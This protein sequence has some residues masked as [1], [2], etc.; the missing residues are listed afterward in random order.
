MIVEYSRQSLKDLALIPSK[1]RFLIQQFIFEELPATENINE[2]NKVESLKGFKNFFK[3][4][5]G[6]YRVGIQKEG[7]KIIV[8][9]I[10][11]R[12]EIYRYFP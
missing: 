4:R 5:I 3:V 2:N 1:S 8:K 7:K 6:N 10:L 11:H 12:K 9:R